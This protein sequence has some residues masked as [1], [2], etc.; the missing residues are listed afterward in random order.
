MTTP[1]LAPLVVY[2]APEPMAIIEPAQ[3]V[4]YPE[5]HLFCDTCKAVKLHKRGRRG[6]KVYVCECGSEI[7]HIIV[8]RATE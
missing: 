3:D 1:T 4:P 5:R 8:M 2:V 6:F 7:I